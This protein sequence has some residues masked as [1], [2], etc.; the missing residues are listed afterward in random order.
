MHKR[1]IHLYVSIPRGEDKNRL[2]VISPI[3]STIFELEKLIENNCNKHYENEPKI[4]VL[5]IKNEMNDDLIKK[6]P[7][8]TCLK[9]KE[10]ISVVVCGEGMRFK[11]F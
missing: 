10:R 5:K 4:K 11:Y 6:Y 7:I 3:S 9:D 8:S 1:N 2:L